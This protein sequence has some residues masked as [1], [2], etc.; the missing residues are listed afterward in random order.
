M[1]GNYLTF[2]LRMPDDV[3]Q[4]EKVVDAIGIGK[5]FHGG[6][7]VAMGVGDE[8]SLND[9]LIEEVGEVRAQELRLQVSGLHK[10]SESATEH[11]G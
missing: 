8:M 5:S 11:V 1:N 10:R 2:V 4:R 6:R 7:C 3:G 9:L